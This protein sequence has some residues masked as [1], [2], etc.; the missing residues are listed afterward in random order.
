MPALIL[1]EGAVESG[2]DPLWWLWLLIAGGFIAVIVY[3]VGRIKPGGPW[4]R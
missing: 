3:L 4:V 1:F 2:P